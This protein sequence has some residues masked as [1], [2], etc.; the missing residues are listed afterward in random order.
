MTKIISAF[1]GTGKSYFH[2]HYDL[3]VL[4]SDSSKFSW[5]EEGVRNPDFP[6]NYMGHI[7]A[8]MDKVDVIL[9]SSHAVVRQ[10]LVKEGIEYTLVF[11]ERSLRD[12]YVE[13]FR[14]RGSAEKFVDLVVANWDTSISELE[15]QE[16]CAKVRLKQG[17][18]LSD[19]LAPR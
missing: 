16:R 2:Q 8:A 3:D 18:Y 9:V 10:A 19:F 11:P 12:E 5:I 17:Q 1:P 6:N 7:K 4:D 14:R 13:R 15:D